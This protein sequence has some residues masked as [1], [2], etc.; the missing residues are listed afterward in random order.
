MTSVCI[1]DQFMNY[2]CNLYNW[3]SPRIS[4]QSHPVSR[5]AESTTCFQEF[6]DSEHVPDQIFSSQVH[7]AVCLGETTSYALQVS[8]SGIE[9][10]LTSTVVTALVGFQPIP[11]PIEG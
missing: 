5:W 10:Q 3:E 11:Q 1:N 7:I 8:R 2:H 9:S 6:C 4:V